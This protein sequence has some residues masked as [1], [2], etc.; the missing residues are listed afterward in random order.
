M[1]NLKSNKKL[2]FKLK[3]KWKKIKFYLRKKY[4]IMTNNKHK[5][6]KII[7]N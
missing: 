5:I 4:N 2:K 6:S 1:I 3:K 7:I